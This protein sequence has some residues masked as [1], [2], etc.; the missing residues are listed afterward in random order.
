MTDYVY[1]KKLRIAKTPIIPLQRIYAVKEKRYGKKGVNFYYY[2]FN[3]HPTGGWM[4]YDQ[5]MQ[6]YGQHPNKIIWLDK[7]TGEHHIPYNINTKQYIYE[8]W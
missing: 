3:T 8:K 6:M 4:E 2:I 5:F 7:P 1:L